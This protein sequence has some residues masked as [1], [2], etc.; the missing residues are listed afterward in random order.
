[1]GKFEKWSLFEHVYPKLIPNYG[2]WTKFR[3]ILLNMWNIDSFTEIENA[4]GGLI[5]VAKETYRKIDP[6]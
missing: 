3:G 4:C 2:G 5:E 1:M 6:H